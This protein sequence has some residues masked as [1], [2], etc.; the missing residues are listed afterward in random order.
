M[1]VITLSTDFGSDDPYLGI[2]KGV[3]LGINPQ[4]R[5]VDLTHALSHHHLQ[6]AA[7]IL[8]TAYPYFPRGT[9]HLTVV[10]AG[11]GGERRLIAVQA[12]DS[13]WIGPDNG[14][15]TLVLK[16]RPEA[17]I[18]QLTNTAF[19][20]KPVSVTFHGRDILAPIAAHLSLGVS[21]NEMGETISDP[22]LL[23]IPEP[24]IKDNRLIGQVLWMDHFGNL[25]TNI[26][27]ETLLPFL[28]GL[29]VNIIVGLNTI[30]ELHQTYSQGCPS[31]IIALIGS[32]GY[33]EIACNLGKASE[34][35]GFQSDKGLKV[36]V[37]SS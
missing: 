34:K 28:S 23:N 3:I 24:E 17:L 30:A 14:L 5:L 7:F 22:F 21:I 29:R 31:Q 9:I 1:S 27:R 4:A 18:I 37:F 25:I 19:F 13:I 32:S 20:L 10:D 15:F 11:V 26:S 36:E 16:T 12:K 33:L 2:M 8:H 35:V 6:E